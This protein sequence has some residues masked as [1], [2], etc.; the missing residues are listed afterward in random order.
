MAS[1]LCDILLF[2]QAKAFVADPS[3]FISAVP[4][5]AAAAEE[6]EEVKEAPQEDSEDSDEDLGLSLFD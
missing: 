1:T 4:V 6:K 3:A 5:A 2:V